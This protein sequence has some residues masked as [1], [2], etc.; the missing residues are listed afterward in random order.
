MATSRTNKKKGETQI[1]WCQRTLEL[2][3][4]SLESIQSLLQSFE[5]KLTNQSDTIKLSQTVFDSFQNR[6]SDLKD[7]LISKCKDIEEKKTQLEKRKEELK[8]KEKEKQKAVQQAKEANCIVDDVHD[9][10]MIAESEADSFQALAKDLFVGMNKI[11]EN[12]IDQ[13]DDPQ[14]KLTALANWQKNEMFAKLQIKHDQQASQELAQTLA[15]GQNCENHRLKMKRK[16]SEGLKRQMR[17][18]L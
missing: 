14:R 2:N 9:L 15:R 8:T 3:S 10:Q 18:H 4:Q 13:V 5:A 12:V 1:D 17:K 16:F 11:M 6:I 7:E